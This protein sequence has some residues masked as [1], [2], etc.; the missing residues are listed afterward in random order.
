MECV[1][2][3]EIKQN[4][5]LAS[6]FV[7]RH[8]TLLKI[9]TRSR[10]LSC[11]DNFETE[12]DKINSGSLFNFILEFL[13]S[14]KFIRVLIFKLWKISVYEKVIKQT[15]NLK[16]HQSWRLGEEE[17]VYIDNLQQTHF[18]PSY[19]DWFDQPF[20]TLLYIMPFK[21]FAEHMV[22]WCVPSLLFQTYFKFTLDFLWQKIF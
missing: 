13:S 12:I 19:L 20:T 14:L 10:V 2:K 4:A 22:L 18:S 9:N 1:S 15:E 8:L 6:N 5:S 3:I 17:N 7:F 16:K 11:I 21:A